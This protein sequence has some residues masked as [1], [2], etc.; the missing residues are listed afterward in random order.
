MTMEDWAKC[1]DLFLTFDDRKILP[2]AGRIANAVCSQ[3]ELK[4]PAIFH[5]YV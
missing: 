1:L 2:H 4:I 5:P 3:L